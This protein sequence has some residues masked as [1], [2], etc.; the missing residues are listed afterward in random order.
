MGLGD[1]T[2]AFDNVNENIGVDRNLP[3]EYTVRIFG[4]V[5]FQ[6][7][8][9]LGTVLAWRGKKKHQLMFSVQCVYVK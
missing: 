3:T 1:S 2:A 5:S 9:L 4:W 6:N 8:S 7:A